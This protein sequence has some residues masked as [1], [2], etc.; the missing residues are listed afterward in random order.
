MQEVVFHHIRYSEWSEEHGNDVISPKGGITL[1][2]EQHP[3]NPEVVNVGYARCS[4]S[5]IFCRKTGR[6]KAQGHLRGRYDAE[7]NPNKFSMEIPGLAE[8]ALKTKQGRSRVF[9]VLEREIERRHH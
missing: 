6:I 1:A 8:E 3:D 7:K 2:I 9:S 5:D 4:L